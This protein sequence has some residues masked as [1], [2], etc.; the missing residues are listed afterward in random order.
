MPSLFLSLLTVIS[1]Q[2]KAKFVKK[3]RDPDAVQ[4]QFLRSL[5]RRHQN[6]EL[7]QRFGLAEI[8]TVA[9]FRERVPILPYSSYEPYI[10][11]S[12]AGERNI[13]T[14]DP[15]IYFNLTSGSTGK[16]KLI[17]VTKRSRRSLD[18]A[19]RAAIGFAV[20]AAQQRG[21]ALGKMLLT[22]S[23]KSLG[24]TPSGIPY[25]PVSSGQLRLSNFL[26][27]Q[28]F[29]HPFETLQIS[30]SLSR[31]YVSL[32]F[33]LQ[34]PQLGIIG[35]NFPVLALRLAEYLENHA[36]HLI[37]DLEKGAIADW[38]KLE[39][40]LRSQL[41]QQFSASPQRAQQLRQILQSE[42]KLTPALVW[43]NLNFLIT[44][45]GGT[46]NFYFE[47]F[48]AA[49]GDTPIFGGIYSS[50]EAT[51]GVYDNFQDGCILAL[52]SGF[53]EFIPADQWEAD[54]P[55]TL[56]PSEVEIGQ[57]YRILV[58][59]YAG[60]YRYD[61]QD[62]VEVTGFYERT[63]IVVFRYRRGGVLSSTTE[64]TTEFHVI[65]VMQILQEKFNL[66]LEDFCITL[67]DDR[68]PAH[69]LVNIE[70][71][72]G[73]SLKEPK[74]FLEQFDRTLKEIHVSYEVKRRD[75]VPPPRLRILQPGS[76]ATVRQRMIQR[77][78]PETQLKLPH[79]SEDRNFLA[80]LAIATEVKLED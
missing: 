3:T 37:W 64:K 36:E 76:F 20:E 34:N 33:A 6:T 49:F 14:A 72:P 32:L 75:Q 70:L 46:S 39:P 56:L 48:P 31:H 15:I 59:N 60:F 25:G 22:S 28:V 7:G 26:Y 66:T 71:S 54:Q 42:G 79:T 18:R 57:Y 2:A 65:R 47:R 62:V 4:A 80:G 68:I 8:T 10:E 45:R 78:I 69:Y 17:P 63:P 27:R 51:F 30:D 67:S 73:L 44:A 5:L 38:L 40:E 21:T 16:Q 52:E 35:A 74:Q 9:Q 19:N 12:A 24:T 23:A 53:F 13:L 1:Q 77:G 11:R 55:Q 41:E 50:A 43:P 58:T 61:I 29:T